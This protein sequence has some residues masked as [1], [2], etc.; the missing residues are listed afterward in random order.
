MLLGTSPGVAADALLSRGGVNV[1][2]RPSP[3]AVSPPGG[4]ASLS[5]GFPALSSSPSETGSAFGGTPG[6]HSHGSSAR[7]Y[8]AER[9]ASPSPV[10]APTVP[11]VTGFDLDARSSEAASRPSVRPTGSSV[12]V[13]ALR[14]GSP[15]A[16]VA[17]PT[18]ATARGDADS[19]HAS[20]PIASR[21][22]ASP[23][24]LA[25]GLSA[26][27]DELET[28]APETRASQAP[29]P[30]RHRA[31]PT[32][33]PPEDTVELEDDTVEY[34][35]ARL[36]AL[37]PLTS[38][39]RGDFDALYAAFPD[40]FGERDAREAFALAATRLRE[41]TK[42]RTVYKR[43]LETS[44]VLAGLGMRSEVIAAA[45]LHGAM[46]ADVVG[47]D[48]ARARCGVE[49]AS[50]AADAAR[51]S[52]FSA[53][54][55]ASADEAPLDEEDK[56][57]F[58]SMLIAMTDARVVLLKLAE[59][60]VDLEDAD[61]FHARRADERRALAEETTAT[62]VPLASRLGVWSLKA[63]LED[64]CFLRL[65]PREHAALAR[66]LERDGRRASVADAVR[67]VAAALDGAGVRAER[68][69]GRPKSLYGVHRKMAEKGLGL[70]DVAEVHDVRA[71]RVIVA[72]EDACYAALDAVL[73]LPGYEPVPSRTKDYVARAKP[74]GYRSLHAVTVDA[75][76]RS[77]EVQIRTPE[78]HAAAE[79]GLAS[80]WRY[81]EEATGTE[82]EEEDNTKN[83]ERRAFIDEQ[84]RW[85]RFA[86]SWQ[87]RLAHDAARA[88]RRA[89]A[90]VDAADAADAASDFDL[91]REL[92]PCPCP[93]PTHRPE[94]ANHEDNHRMGLGGAHAHASNLSNLVS[95]D[96]ASFRDGNRDGSRGVSPPPSNVSNV[97]TVVAVVD[98]R[99]RV[100]DVPRGARL[101]DVDLASLGG[102]GDARAAEFSSVVS[103]AV[104]REPVPPGAEVAV[105]LR[106]GDLV[107]VTRARLAAADGGSPGAS[108]E[109]GAAAAALGA[110]A[111]EEARRRAS[112]GDEMVT[113]NNVVS[114]KG[115][116]P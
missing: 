76:G 95:A 107:E 47:V 26:M 25:R 72:D 70:N 30:P 7:R 10:L 89:E 19:D 42:R 31:S 104:N 14:L 51:L 75:R 110:A 83:E 77:C 62:F 93:F 114:A 86:L 66:E 9:R 38:D 15:G 63:R 16:E 44:R 2:A 11:T 74:N 50:M 13:S 108:R 67:D 101:S 8:R 98:G 99:M 79:Y 97:V 68:V 106:V 116:F 28:L 102:P 58:R 46:D 71:V 90:F 81:K 59:R 109:L 54:A 113:A 18:D 49:A 43:A 111:A 105:T 22:P 85:A 94:C 78:M 40:A 5:R 73:R 27:R 39:E 29:K 112:L 87:G 37:A 41:D 1:A 69:Y 12:K 3:S 45:L 17:S 115:F 23:G 52:L 35:A 48:E 96:S 103:V 34:Y 24:G 53:L 36:E 32:K 60:V 64:A 4:A 6:S 61:A 21:S 55:R 82:K 80:H 100:V 84:V 88:A 92:A 65:N 20:M 57:R 56:R 33:I 91:C